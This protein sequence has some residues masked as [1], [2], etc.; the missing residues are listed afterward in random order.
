MA[1][2]YGI[3]I[4]AARL[5]AKLTQEVCADAVG[6]TKQ[7]W[8]H[9]ERERQEPSFTVLA[10]FCEMA[11]VSADY[12]IMGRP[13][14]VMSPAVASVCSKLEALEKEKLDAVLT[15]IGTGRDD[16][17]VVAFADPKNRKR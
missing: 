3:R 13:S 2:G 6:R 8:S 1:I 14:Y 12:I 16:E 15:L 11:N 10:K 4:R 9:Y 17:K 7:N 5:R